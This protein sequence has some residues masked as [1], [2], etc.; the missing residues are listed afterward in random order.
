MTDTPIPS[1]PSLGGF[2][3]PALVLTLL[4][5]LAYLPLWNNNFVTW[6][7]P[8]AITDNVY[9]RF[10]NGESL[11]W[12]FTTFH[13][14]NWIPLT[15][16]TLAL[17][18]QIHRLDPRVF[19]FTN[20]ALHI[21]N[22]LLVFGLCRKVLVLARRREEEQGSAASDDQD[23]RF[24]TAFLTAVLF[25]LHPI[26]VESV[27]WATERKDVLYAFFY[28]SAL[29][30][31]LDYASKGA[32]SR[33][34]LWACGGLF[35]LS[36]M[37]KPMAVTLPVV[38]LILDF[39]PLRRLREG[40][41]QQAILEKIPFFLMA[42]ALGVLTVFS[43]A[44]TNAF[45][46]LSGLTPQF[47]VMNAFRSLVFYLWKMILPI[48]LVPLYP[49]PRDGNGLYYAQ[50]NLAVA[51]VLAFTLVAWVYRRKRPSMATAWLFYLATLAPVLGIVQVGSQAAAD[52]YAYVPSLAFFLPL[53]AFLMR[54]A[55]RRNLRAGL[56]GVLALALGVLT[57]NQLGLWRDSIALWES[58]TAAY[59]DVSQIAHTNLANAYKQAGRPDDALREYDRAMAI[60]PPQAFTHDG[61][62]TALLDK[63]L[64]DEAVAEFKTA[65]DLDPHYA[66][67]HRNLWFAYRRKGMGK[68]ALEEIQKAVVLDPHFADAY[69]DLGISYGEMGQGTQAERAFQE[70]LDLDPTNSQYLMNL[71]TTYQREQRWEDAVAGYR[72]ILTLDPR[73]IMAW[74]DLGNTYLLSGDYPD[75]AQ[76]LEAANQLAPGQKAIDQKLTEA[77]S[78][79]HKK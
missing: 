6:D 23:W 77:Y 32:A 15:W 24:W 5:F 16:L 62:G 3:P 42:L 53:A 56:S 67:P 28:L 19:H 9:L 48:N 43:Q 25:G 58:V 41:R 66:S 31:Y 14:G 37:S 22:T 51:A 61:K 21:A 45:S 47:R 29:W 11:R 1:R 12:M 35:L 52:R 20:L 74:Y 33:V 27:A 7:D 36:L 63:G 50:N 70:A 17:D 13:T 34:K 8:L 57:W 39:W 30:L 59:P 4:V 54:W 2:W 44:T 78:K 10:L 71:A 26:H 55:G 69:S 46:T 40:K 73:N 72:K 38:F 64:T 49:V 68:E 18:Y 75:A 79:L 60:P 76:A 65:I